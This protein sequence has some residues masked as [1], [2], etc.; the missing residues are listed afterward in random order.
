MGQASQ[1]A[2]WLDDL[3][4]VVTERITENL[5]LRKRALA[6]TPRSR[7]SATDKALLLEAV[8]Q[9]KIL[10]ARNLLQ[11]TG[12]RQAPSLLRPPAPSRPN[13]T[14]HL[15]LGYV[16]LGRGSYDLIELIDGYSRLLVHW[17]SATTMLAGEVTAVLQEALELHGP[18][19]VGLSVVHDRGSQP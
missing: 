12:C 2:H 4:A 13:P 18:A 9:A 11:G 5:Q 16:R 3:R 7:H 14:G 8:G 1:L 10:A 17:R 6:V 19:G 15:D